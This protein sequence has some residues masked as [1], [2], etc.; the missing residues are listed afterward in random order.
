MVE[1]LHFSDMHNES[2]TVRITKRIVEQFNEKVIVAVTGDI[3]C[4]S[5]IAQ[6]KS[7]LLIVILIHHFNIANREQIV[8]FLSNLSIHQDAK[9][10]DSSRS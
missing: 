8:E 2:E 4:D 5:G 1:I 10:I 3:T 7:R 9:T 6:I